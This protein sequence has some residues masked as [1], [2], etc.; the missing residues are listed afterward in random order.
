[1]TERERIK[2]AKDYLNQAYYIDRRIKLNLEKL[3]AMKS[4]LY[5]KGNSYQNDGSQHTF[6]DNSIERA[7]TKV[8]EYEELIKAEI[9]ELVCKRIEIDKAIQSVEDSVQRELLE[10]R[11]L[12]F[13]KWNS[14]YNKRKK[15]YIKGIAESMGYSMSQIFK[16][17]NRAL[18][19]MRL[20]ES[21]KV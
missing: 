12:A 6:G 21:K 4:S 18:L 20:K 11:Y 10:R 15:Q 16:L 8:I 17:H 19:N 14:Y 3:E 13:E 7:I 5:G 1:M 2:Y 9:E